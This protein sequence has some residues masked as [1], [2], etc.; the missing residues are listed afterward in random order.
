[1]T[2]E[3]AKAIRIR[4]QD[5]LD[6]CEGCPYQFERNAYYIAC[7]KCEIG[8]EMR[9]LADSIGYRKV[10]SGRKEARPI[11]TPEEEEYLWNNRHLRKK[12]IAAKLNRPLGAVYKK[13][14]ELKKRYA[15]YQ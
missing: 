6:R 3:E 5:L 4:I 11:W 10:N 8:K 9:R 13:L 1:M 15:V 2:R 7:R 12:D 14:H